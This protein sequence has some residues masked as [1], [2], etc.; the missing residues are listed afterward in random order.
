MKKCLSCNNVQETGNFCGKCG[1]NQFEIIQNDDNASNVS[2]NSELYKANKESAVT[3]VN[4]DQNYHSKNPSQPNIQVEKVKEKSRAYFSH[5]VSY[6][7]KPSLIFSNGQQEFVNS[8][9]TIVTFSLILSLS[10]YLLINNITKSIFGDYRSMFDTSIVSPPFFSI[11]FS[12]FIFCLISIAIVILSLFIILKIF[13]PEKSVKEIV[14]Y[15]GVHSIPAAILVIIGL[16]LVLI[17]SLVAGYI[18]LALSFTLIILIIPLYIISRL[19][20]SKVKSIDSY[21]GYLLYIVFFSILY[22][23]VIA[24]IGDATIGQFIDQLDMY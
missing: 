8:M 18:F 5:F 22:A 21:Y 24:I 4:N 3:S 2:T 15:L 19:I 1:G 14:S 17:K 23:I 9:I 11:F 20:V 12:A 13:G 16:L 10:I 7:K 6:L